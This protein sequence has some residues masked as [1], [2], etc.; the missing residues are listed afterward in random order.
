M[1]ARAKISI[2]FA[3]ALVGKIK[4]VSHKRLMDLQ[5]LNLITN[6]TT[7]ILC[8]GNYGSANLPNLL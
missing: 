8:A 4:R 1:N 2:G 5:N 7:N 6:T 3:K